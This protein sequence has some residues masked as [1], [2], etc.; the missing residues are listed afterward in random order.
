MLM[1]VEHNKTFVHGDMNR[2]L[3]FNF[4]RLFHRKKGGKLLQNVFQYMDESALINA[5]RLQN[6]KERK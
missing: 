2:L 5:W 4:D 6:P 3:D 1:D